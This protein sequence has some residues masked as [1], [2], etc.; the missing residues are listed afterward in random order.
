M[1]HL[2]SPALQRILQEIVDSAMEIGGADFG[3]I[4]LLDL[5]TSDLIIVAQR[6]FPKF[7]LEYWDRVSK[8]KWT[9][10]SA[11]QE[12]KRIIVEDVENSPIF[13]GTEALEIQRQVGVRAIQ[14]TPLFSQSG[15]AI[16]MFSTHYKKPGRPT[17]YSLR[18]LDLLAQLGADAIEQVQLQDIIRKSQEEYKIAA[19]KA[20]EANQL[21]DAFL[22]MVSHEL[23][24]PLTAIL[25]WAQL[26]QKS[27][28]DQ[29]K[30]KKGLKTIELNA[31]S[32]RRLI[33]D[34]IDLA[35][36]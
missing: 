1:I 4:Q 28:F 14:S 31:L 20:E 26:L 35:K 3:N 36:I 21:K 33:D 12:R 9:C 13:K 10:G 30:F 19:A 22:A 11:M 18:L 7:W 5:P 34:L 17:E 2:L 27:N 32:Q 29:V 16:G 23:R 8:G 24:T 15:E 25:S 6:G